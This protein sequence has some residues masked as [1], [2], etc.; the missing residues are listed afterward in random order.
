[1]IYRKIQIYKNDLFCL[2]KKQLNNVHTKHVYIY[3][4]PIGKVYLTFNRSN[5]F[6]FLCNP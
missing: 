5:Y 1:M 2:A 3:I 6:V 4:D